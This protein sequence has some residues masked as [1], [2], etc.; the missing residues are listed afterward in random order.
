MSDNHSVEI[1]S[2]A[3]RNLHQHHT[4]FSHAYSAAQNPMTDPQV[5]MHG[6]HLPGQIDDVNPEA[7]I[8][9]GDPMHVHYMQ[10]H[11]HPLQNNDSGLEDDGEE[12]GG[13]EGME[14][15]GSS[16]AGNLGDPHTAIP[17]RSQGTNQLQ[18][19]FQGEVYVF[20]SVAPEK[21]QAV[22]LL[23]G[24][25][26]APSGLPAVPL[27]GHQLSKGFTD[28]VTQRM[29]QSHRMQSLSRFRE[30]RKE[31]NY[32]KKI[33][34]SVR[35]EVAERMQRNKGQFTSSKNVSEDAPPPELTWESNPTWAAETN[36]PAICR[37]CGT[38]EKSTPMMRRG[39]AGP[40]SLC[41]AC[42]LMWANKGTLRDLS[43]GGT[44]LSI[45]G[46]S[47]NS[48]EQNEA[49]GTDIKGDSQVTQVVMALPSND[50]S[51]S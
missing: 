4:T 29:N 48:G 37:H 10:E 39:P 28:P 2:Q 11:G 40:R 34:Y 15:D 6:M 46:H 32:D 45:Q 5:Q 20:D 14:G 27:Y 42:G 19:S 8:H 7:Q 24:G 43:K 47:T 41:N 12:G 3:N 1:N 23:L 9:G 22:L 13:S 51:S 18:L 50:N 38:S 31:R 33:R 44:S 21:V 36:E 30:K 16:D 25:R 49:N 35:K 17:L 26:E